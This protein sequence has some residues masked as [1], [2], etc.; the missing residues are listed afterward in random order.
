MGYDL[1]P[2]DTL[3]IKKKFVPEAIENKWLCLWEHD[4]KIVSGYLSQDNKQIKIQAD[5]T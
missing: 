4:P 5:P 3:K 2:Q 1:F